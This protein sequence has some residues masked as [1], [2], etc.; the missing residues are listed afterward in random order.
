MAR[1]KDRKAVAAK[2]IEMVSNG[3]TIARACEWAGVAPVTFRQWKQGDS[4]LA[5]ALKKAEIDFEAMHLANITTAS[6]ESWQASAWLLERKFKKRYAKIT[7]AQDPKPKTEDPSESA[8]LIRIPTKEEFAKQ[9]EQVD[10]ASLPMKP[11][12]SRKPKANA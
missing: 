3:L 10:K 11:K 9:K 7:Y 8:V 4:S 1:V 5:I 6:A 12:R 2:V